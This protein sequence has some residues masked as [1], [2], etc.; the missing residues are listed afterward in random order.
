MVWYGS[1]R[2]TNTLQ[3]DALIMT[4]N[5]NLENRRIWYYMLIPSWKDTSTRDGLLLMAG[6][7]KPLPVDL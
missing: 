4:E 5:V 3:G 1:S 7:T 2:H 6:C